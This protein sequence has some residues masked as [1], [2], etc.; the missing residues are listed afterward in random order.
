MF[1]RFRTHLYY[2]TGYGS[3]DPGSKISVPETNGSTLD[4]L[5]PLLPK[6]SHYFV[7]QISNERGNHT[8]Y[9][10]LL[11]I[12]SISVEEGKFK[13]VIFHELMNSTQAC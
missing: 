3:D 7:V 9:A 4:K 8:C 11:K 6:L 13:H 1:S 12:C 2:K 10:R 5:L